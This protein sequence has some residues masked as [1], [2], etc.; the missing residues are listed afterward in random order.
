MME[1]HVKLLRD[2]RDKFLLNNLSGKCFVRS[3]YTYSPPIAD[4]ISKH[5]KLRTIVRVSLLP[6]VGMSW[7][8]LKLGLSITTGLMLFFSIGMIGLISSLRRKKIKPKLSVS[9]SDRSIKS[10]IYK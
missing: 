6:V 1:P 5:D 7:I 8:A 9:N 4:F 2:F 3:Y 10:N